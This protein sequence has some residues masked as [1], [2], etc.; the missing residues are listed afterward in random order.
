[1][2]GP[3]NDRKGIFLDLLTQSSWIA[4]LVSVPLNTG[5]DPNLLRSNPNFELDNIQSDS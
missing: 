4:P 1:M 3:L 5:V 2:D